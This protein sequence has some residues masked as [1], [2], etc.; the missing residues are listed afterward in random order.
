[1]AASV[2]KTANPF[3]ITIEL[4]FI[5]LSSEISS[6]HTL[7]LCFPGTPSRLGHLASTPAKQGIKSE[8]K[9]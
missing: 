1:M 4:I 2:A 8:M 6:I 3:P 5:A 9:R 7:T